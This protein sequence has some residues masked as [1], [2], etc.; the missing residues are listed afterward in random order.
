MELAKNMTADN[1]LIL[2]GNQE[3]LRNL[4]KE[5]KASVLFFTSEKKRVLNSLLSR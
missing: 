2:N 1:Q 5:T 4:A 3:E